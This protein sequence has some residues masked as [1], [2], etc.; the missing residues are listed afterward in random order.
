MSQTKKIQGKIF[1]G[2]SGA[3]GP[4]PPRSTSDPALTIS[5]PKP[6]T[7]QTPAPAPPKLAKPEAVPSPKQDERNGDARP[8]RHRLAEK[9]KNEYKGAE[10]YRLDQDRERE[11]HWKRWGPYVSD[12]Q[13]VRS[14]ILL[15]CILIILYNLRQPSVRITLPMA[16]LGATSLTNMPARALTGGARMVSQASQ[17]ITDASTSRSHCGTNRIVFS[18]SVSLASLDI[19]GTMAKTSRNCIIISTQL[20][21]IP[22]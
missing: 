21:H 19:K 4:Q 22:T 11:L 1:R 20:R 5:I 15:Y 13:W 6:A 14:V 18:R 10:R 3:G 17:I 12:R 8:F 7:S 9:L 2:E 16:T